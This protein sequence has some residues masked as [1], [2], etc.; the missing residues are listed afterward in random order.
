M[1][2]PHRSTWSEAVESDSASAVIS[3]EDVRAAA[4]RIAGVAHRT[5]VL[6]SRT[7]DERA[8]G[9]VFVKCENLQRIGAYKFRGAYNAISRLDVDQLARGVITFSSGNHAQAVALAAGML[10]SRAVVV[11]PADTPASKREATAG[12][13]AEIVTFDRYTDDRFQITAALAEEQGLT[14]I[15]PFDHPDVMAG[16]GT[17]ALELFE[18]VGPLDMLMTPVGGGALLAGCA[19]TAV[20]LHPSIRV[21]GVEPTAADDTRCSLRAGRR[22]SIPVPRTIAD[23]VTATTPGELTFAVNRRLVEDVVVVDDHEI[24]AAVT[25]LV[26]RMKIVAEPAGALAIAALLAGRVHPVPERIGVVVSGGNID[27]ERLGELFARYPAD[28]ELG[29]G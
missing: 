18:D 5:P 28:Q 4:R 17:A 26:E 8:G 1:T 3:I 14:V 15:P 7:L 16:Q 24:A 25:F 9:R 12:Y 19:T 2:N 29:P 23:A 27:A 13:G 11:M 20:A 6:T 22:V 10:G 21:I